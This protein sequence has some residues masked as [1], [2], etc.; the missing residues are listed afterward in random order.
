[1]KKDSNSQTKTGQKTK[2][3]KARGPVQQESKE[4]MAE[5]VAKL[6]E[7]L[8]Q[9]PTQ[10]KAAEGRPKGAPAPNRDRLTVG[11]DLGDQWS[12]YCILGLEGETLGEGQLRT[13][14]EDLAAYGR[15][16]R[17]SLRH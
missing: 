16:W 12:N 6:S 2:P 4:V 7:R 15:I 5:L 13:T 10:E 14:R 1:M 3:A 11:V 8:E 17:H 9:K